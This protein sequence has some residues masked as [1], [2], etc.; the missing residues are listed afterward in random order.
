M[1]DLFGIEKL[2]N[3]LLWSVYEIIHIWTAVVDES[4]GW[5]SRLIF[6]LKQLE[7]RS[8]KKSGPDFFQASPLENIVFPEIQWEILGK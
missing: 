3:I 6:Q 5:S 8:L 7:R 1:T 2:E 4:E